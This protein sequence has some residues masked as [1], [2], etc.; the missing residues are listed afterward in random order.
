MSANDSMSEWVNAS[1]YGSGFFFLLLL[2]TP[3]ANYLLQ[4]LCSPFKHIKVD[5]QVSS[6]HSMM[7]LANEL[8]LN[9]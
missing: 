1:L 7:M 8:D 9:W 6:S 4:T 2:Q 5:I 3:K